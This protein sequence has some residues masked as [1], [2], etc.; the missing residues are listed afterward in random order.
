M[1][2]LLKDFG[3]ILEGFWKVFSRILDGFWKDFE[4]NFF[5]TRAPRK[6]TF[7][8]RLREEIGKATF[9]F[10]MSKNTR[11]HTGSEAFRPGQ[12]QKYSFTRFHTG[13]D[14]VVGELRNEK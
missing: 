6:Y 5:Y 10:Y 11:F 9:F 4:Q 8:Y 14:E 7:S 1:E 12:L 2:G 3:R 13:S